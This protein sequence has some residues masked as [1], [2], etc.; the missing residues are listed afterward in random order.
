MWKSRPA[1]S[2]FRFA[3][4]IVE[5]ERCLARACFCRKCPV[6]CETLN[7]FKFQASLRGLKA[8]WI[9]NIFPRRSFRRKLYA[10]IARRF[11]RGRTMLWKQ[12]L[13]REGK[14]RL[15]KVDLF[16]AGT[17]MNFDYGMIG[18]ELMWSCQ[19]RRQN[20]GFSTYFIFS[21]KKDYLHALEI[22]K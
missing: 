8:F 5:A 19:H 20:H 16:T 3:N 1:G 6:D 22:K 13:R 18:F 12:F 9:I 15:L 21:Y 17:F 11:F 2:F 10:Q 14:R 4:P 7:G